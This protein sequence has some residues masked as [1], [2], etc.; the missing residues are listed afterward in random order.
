MA[1]GE[2]HQR[3]TKAINFRMGWRGHLWQG[4]FHSAPMDE[5][6]LLETARYIE[7]N[8]VEGEDRQIST[9]LP[10]E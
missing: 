9:R 4:R 7:L 6:Y 10:L 5:S 3:Y 2:I 8:P 1:I